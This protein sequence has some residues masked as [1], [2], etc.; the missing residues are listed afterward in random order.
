MRATLSAAADICQ[1]TARKARA[2]ATLTMSALVRL[3]VDGT[4]ASMSGTLS[5]AA[6]RAFI[7]GD[8]K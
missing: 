7:F 4:T 5:T 3:C 8:A 6:G 2:T 1:D